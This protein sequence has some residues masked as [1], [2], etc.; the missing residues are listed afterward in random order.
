MLFTDELFEIVDKKQKKYNSLQ[1][2]NSKIR[3]NITELEVIHESNLVKI[4][5]LKQNVKNLKKNVKQTS[6]S[7]ERLKDLEVNNDKFKKQM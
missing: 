3:S 6:A 7:V 4:I 1:K 2:T 5:Q